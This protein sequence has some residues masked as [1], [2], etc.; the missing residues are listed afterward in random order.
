MNIYLYNCSYPPKSLF[1]RRKGQQILLNDRAGSIVLKI[2]VF[3][4]K[5]I[6]MQKTLPLSLFGILLILMLFTVFTQATNYG[7][8]ADEDV[9]AREGLF[10][11]QWYGTL[12]KNQS[13]LQY[14]KDGHE[15]EHGIIFDAVVAAVQQITHNQWT[16]EAISI[17]LAGV[18]G[19]V[20]MALCGLEL[21]G[22]WFAFL[23]ALSLWLYPRFF[24][25]IFNNSKDIPFASANAFLLW[26]ILLLIRQWEEEK[27]Y[28]RNSFLVAFLLALTVAI[29]V[30]AVTWYV[31]LLLLLAGWWLF[32]FR[33][34][35]QEGKIRQ[36]V[37]KQAGVVGII[38][39]GSF[40]GI[41]AMWPYVFINP[42]VNF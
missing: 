33:R 12:G 29:R 9:Q 28:L 7:L 23:A 22:W 42:Y 15:P 27:K 40:L 38:G 21:G 16:V 39:I 17:G 34:V 26:S 25:A 1:S 13:F 30:N 14:L 5:T 6:F 32:N 2:G 31:L 41:M 8:T 11:Y 24:G 10:V 19:V 35:R 4:N 20:A 36:A 3:M 18:L 37:R